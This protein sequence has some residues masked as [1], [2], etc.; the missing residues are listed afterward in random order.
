[1]SKLDEAIKKNIQISERLI[2]SLNKVI[3]GSVIDALTNADIR[4]GKVMYN[5]RNI[6][7]IQNLGNKVDN[8]KGPLG[9]LARSL[10]S[11]IKQILDITGVQMSKYSTSEKY[12]SSN[13]LEKVKTHAATTVKTRVDLSM[14]YG[15]IKQ[16]AISLLSKPDGT[17]LVELRE[18]LKTKVVDNDLASKYFSRWT[19]DIYFQ[20][21]RAG[22]NEL[23]KDLGLRFGIYQ[24]GLMES[25]RTF[26]E[27]RNGQVYHIDEIM[28]WENLDFKGKPETG[29]NP[30]IDLGGYN[31]RHRID[32]ISDELAFELKPELK[33]KYS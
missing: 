18:L 30:I 8:I 1:M 25:S 20:Y 26:C 32:W 6:L 12:N 21:Q 7:I 3:Y 33:E 11:G 10:F 24:G 29:Y 23:R 27:D 14:V 2:K 16:S 4:D 9:N 5:E 19:H 15:E 22:A 13:V 17:S 31:C 28:E